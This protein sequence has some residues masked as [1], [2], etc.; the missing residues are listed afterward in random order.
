MRWRMKTLLS[1]ILL[2]TFAFALS[3][4]NSVVDT[5][6]EHDN[7][8]QSIAVQGRPSNASGDVGQPR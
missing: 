3:G 4:C 2:A 6:A 1:A 5:R 7:H 8:R